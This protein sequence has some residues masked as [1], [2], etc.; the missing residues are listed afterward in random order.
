MGISS[1]EHISPAPLLVGGL[2]L[3][4]RCGAHYTKMQCGNA[5]K[6][7]PNGWAFSRITA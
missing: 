1:P 5:K 7:R 2:V 6:A 4:G 3:N